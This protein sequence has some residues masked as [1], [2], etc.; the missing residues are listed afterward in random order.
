MLDLKSQTVLKILIKECKNGGYKIIETSDIIS[1]LPER[2]KTD[3]EGLKNILTYLEHSDCISIKYDDDGVYCLAVLPY[4]YKMV[5][6]KQEQKKKGITLP[7][8]IYIIIFFLSF[9]AS[10]LGALLSKLIYF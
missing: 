9:A 8:K 2:Y 4:A 1:A 6:T 3:A 10:F 7:L 5:E